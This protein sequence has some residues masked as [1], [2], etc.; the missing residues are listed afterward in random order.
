MCGITGYLSSHP[1]PAAPIAAMNRLLR[2]RGPDDEGYVLISG[3]G[4]RPTVCRG[5]DTAPQ[6]SLV[7]LPFRP[8]RD[9]ADYANAGVT[10]ALGHRRLS[11]VD[12]S[13]S[14]H[15]PM[16]TPDRRFWIVYNGEIYNHEALRLQLQG[17]GYEFH[18][19]SDTEVV[20]AAY[21][22]WGA[23]CLSLLKGMW[24][25]AIY[26][27]LNGRLFLARDRF[28]VKPLYYWVAPGNVLCFA[29]EIKAFTAY[30]GWAA[31]INPQRA[32]DFL[33]WN[34]LDHTDETLF[35]GVYQ[36]LP[37]H[38][39]LVPASGAETDR[40]G[41]I[42]ATRWYSLEA[43]RFTGSFDDA[44]AIFRQRFTDSVR[45][46][47]RADVPVGSCL[48]G[49]LDSS[50]IVCA[51]NRLLQQQGDASLQKSFSACT[52]EK[53]FDER[54]WIDIVAGE[55]GVD[56]H[57]V[58]PALED[59][60]N[61]L[62]AITWHQ[63]EPFGGTSIFA[64]WSVFKLAAENSVKV[65]LDGQGADE[66]L[67]GYHSFF[68]PR[69]AG[70]LRSGRLIQLIREMRQ[71]R[72]LHGH[73]PL[74]MTMWAADVFLPE[75]IRNRLRARVGRA[76]AAPDWLDLDRLGAVAVD[77]RRELGAIDSVQAMSVAQL[78][79]SNLQMLLHWED[80]DSMAHSIE[81]R[82]P[83][84][85]HELVEF[86]VSLPDDFKLKSAV[87]KRVQRAGMSGILPDRIRDRM[88]KIGFQTPE[89][90]WLRKQGASHFIAK[91]DDAVRASRGILKPEAFDVLRDMILGKRPFSYLIWRL[92]SFGEWIKAFSVNVDAASKNAEPGAT[93]LMPTEQRLLDRRPG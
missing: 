20:L 1:I 26:D 52:V 88:D 54:E 85:D 87:T 2:H 64:Q 55:T 35:S 65:M 71:A 79:A 89:E 31:R 30:P 59:L 82:V 21:Q 43:G 9:I 78:T 16:C 72:S 22:E 49:G 60:F 36:L 70:L 93:S 86:V 37:G 57:F 11:I 62:G 34:Q 44:A 50:S 8:E 41:R 92:I 48:S 53:R 69:L 90:V 66:M 38:C 12:L 23:D 28:G 47:L 84:L 58:Y 25:F 67:A 4:T 80:R 32:Y 74:L 83:F 17:L 61:D 81:S 19:S 73:S 68:G 15:Q 18:S 76:H 5:A 3:P 29:S 13:P 56:V 14:G 24:A 91:L 42:A 77:P 39:M 6:W 46:H 40:D 33:V 51:V 10:V 45:E 7:P 75:D 63:D 27:R